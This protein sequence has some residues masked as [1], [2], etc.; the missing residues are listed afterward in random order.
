MFSIDMQ[1]FFAVYVEYRWL[2]SKFFLNSFFLQQWTC[3]QITENGG[4]LISSTKI[5]KLAEET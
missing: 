4:P 3:L 5:S 1:A 2:A